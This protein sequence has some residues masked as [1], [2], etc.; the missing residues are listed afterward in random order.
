[1]HLFCDKRR[2]LRYSPGR[3][4]PHGC[5]VTLYVGKWSE[6][7]QWHLLCS[8]PAFSHFIHYPQA[9]WSLLVLISVWVCLCMFWDP[10]GLL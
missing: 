8:L 3:G 4:N 9:K 2:S 5:V 7:E 1:M 10:V 6:R